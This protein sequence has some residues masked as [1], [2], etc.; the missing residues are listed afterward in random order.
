[1]DIE[2]IAPLDIRLQAIC[3]QIPIR[4]RPE[5]RGYYDAHENTVHEYHIEYERDALPERQSQHIRKAQGGDC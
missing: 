4:H 2:G 1:M 3:A 5:E